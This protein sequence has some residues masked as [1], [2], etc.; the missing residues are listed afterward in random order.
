MGISVRVICQPV[1]H[2][3]RGAP[4]KPTHEQVKHLRMKQVPSSMG[5]F[6][7]A[8]IERRLEGASRTRA[9]LSRA[10]M[11]TGR[12]GFTEAALSRLFE[13]EAS[14]PRDGWDYFVDGCAAYLEAHPIELWREALTAWEADASGRTRASSRRV[15]RARQQAQAE[16]QTP[17]ERRPKRGQAPD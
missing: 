3:T 5:S 9:D 13:R 17:A 10:M 8:V 16:P 2:V 6:L 14:T 15:Q 4:M 7:I 11:A 12:R 1:P